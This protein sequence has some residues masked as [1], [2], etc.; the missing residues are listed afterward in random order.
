MSLAREASVLMELKKSDLKDFFFLL[1]TSLSCWRIH[2]PYSRCPAGAGGRG[3]P[4]LRVSGLPTIYFVLLRRT[5]I[6][7]APSAPLVRG[8]TSPR[9]PGHQASTVREGQCHRRRCQL[10]FRYFDNP[11]CLLSAKCDPI[12]TKIGVKR[13]YW[14]IQRPNKH[15]SFLHPDSYFES[16]E[17]APSTECG[18]RPDE[19]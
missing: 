6:L 19:A 5:R 14:R 3:T 2:R 15:T 8:W 7:R 13:T 11:V 9:P 18:G 10:Q 1:Y 16:D 17:S 4:T 12:D